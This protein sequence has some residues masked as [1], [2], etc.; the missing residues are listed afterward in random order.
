M[1]ISRFPVIPYPANLLKCTLLMLLT[2][3]CKLPV[4]VTA[5]KQNIIPTFDGHHLV[6]VRK[7]GLQ[8]T[9][10]DNFT[11]YKVTDKSGKYFGKSLHQALKMEDTIL[12]MGTASSGVEVYLLKGGGLDANKNGMYL[13]DSL[14]AEDT[15]LFE[16]VFYDTGSGLTAMYDFYKTKQYSLV[17]HLNTRADKEEA[18]KKFVAAAR[19]IARSLQ[20]QIPVMGINFFDIDKDA[21]GPDKNVYVTTASDI[22]TLEGYLDKALTDNERDMLLQCLATKY[23]LVGNAQKAGEY[24]TQRLPV[25]TVSLKDSIGFNI[26]AAGA[27]ILEQAV[28]QK[29]LFFNESHVDVRTRIFLASLL[30]GLKKL[31]YNKLAL[32]ALGRDSVT[33]GAIENGYYTCEP[34]YG[35]LIRIALA[36]GFTLINYEDTSGVSEWNHRDSVQAFNITQKLKNTTDT[37][38]LI[39]LAGHDHIFKQ[40][41]NAAV[42]PMAVYFQ[43]MSGINPYSIDSDN[44]NRVRYTGIDNSMPYILCRHMIPVNKRPLRYDLQ[45]HYPNNLVDDNIVPTPWNV[46]II[47]APVDMLLLVYSWQEY[48]ESGRINGLVPVYASYPASTAVHL[49]L[50]S[51]SYWLCLFDK[52]GKLLCQQRINIP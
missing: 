23:T 47:S 30:P 18:R 15:R 6:R 41:D 27:Y 37:G 25:R 50:K 32:E 48:K 2:A 7:E 45:V 36:E 35:N 43:R 3:A 52:T 33:A 22:A 51:D 21:R 13:S 8:L 17:F 40:V 16:Q 39:V 24:T 12:L 28:T 34:N 31:G 29:A 44:A 38:K 4:K 5:D 42:V 49:P 10:G 9:F 20:L 46:P 11:F 26:T 14:P 1:K 19:E